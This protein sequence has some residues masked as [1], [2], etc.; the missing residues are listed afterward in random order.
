MQFS[1]IFFLFL[2]QFLGVVVYWS[3]VYVNRKQDDDEDSNDSEISDFEIDE[4]TLETYLTPIDDED[5]DNPIDEYIAFQQVLTRTYHWLWHFHP[6][7]DYKTTVV[8]HSFHK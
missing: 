8:S 4:T 5:T 2:S 7:N 3:I 6:I 1:W